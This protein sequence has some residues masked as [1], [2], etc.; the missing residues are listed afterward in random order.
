M[1]G[2]NVNQVYLTVSDIASKNQSGGY[3][4]DE[5]A[6]NFMALTQ[7]EIINEIYQLM[8]VNR[9]ATALIAPAIK[10]SNC[11]V[12]NSY[13]TTPSDYTQLITFY[14][15]YYDDRWVK[16]ESEYLNQTEIGERLRSQIDEPTLDYPVVVE[17][18]SGLKVYPNSIGFGEIVYIY[19]YPDPV[20]ATTGDP[21]VYDPLNS[22]DFVLDELFFDI[23]VYRVCL[24]FGISVK[25]ANL[26]QTTVRSILKAI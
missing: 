16:K 25:D 26:Q 11:S 23:V 5:E 1:A 14:G 19:D 6:S 13:I 15:K 4:S 21:P 3:L 2:I 10:I 7:R 22:V 8:D 20:Y 12:S 17:D 9:S 18:N 24:L